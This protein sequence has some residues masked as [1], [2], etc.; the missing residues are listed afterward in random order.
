LLRFAPPALFAAAAL[1]PALL[2]SGP[3]IGQTVSGCGTATIAKADTNSIAKLTTQIACFTKAGAAASKAVADRQARVKALTP[4]PTP[5][6]APTPTP[7]A[8]SWVAC[9]KED[10]V[11]TVPGLALVRYG[12]ADKFRYLTTSTAVLCANKVFTDPITGTA[13]TCSY[14]LNASIPAGTAAAPAVVVSPTPTPTPT[15]VPTATP[16]PVAA[17]KSMTIGINVT[18][19]T[20]YNSERTFANLAQQSGGWKDPSAGW[21]STAAAKLGTTGFPIVDGQALTLNAPRQVWGGQ[22]VTISCTWS[23]SGSIRVDGLARGSISASG[24]SF[25]V[26]AGFDITKGGYPQILFYLSGLNAAKPFGDLDCREAGSQAVG[27]FEK[28]LVDELSAYK[29]L[30]FLDWSNT[31]GNPASVTLDNRSTPA[32]GGADG[33]PIETQVDLA[34]AAGTDAWFT[35][36]Y[37]ADEAYVRAM[38]ELVRD[39]L[40]KGHRAYFELSNEIWNYA[41]PVARQAS[42]EGSKQT[43]PL[44]TDYYSNNPLRA[45]QKSLWFHKILTDVFKADPS[46][47]VRVVA[48]QSDN[49]WSART[50]LA[51]P[52]LADYVDALAIAP[53]FGHSFFNAPDDKPTLADLDRLFVKLEANRVNSIAKV[54]ENKAAA[55]KYG[56]RLIAYEGGQHII[57]N[58]MAA[59]NEVYTAMQ[60]DKRMGEI[61]DRYLADWKAISPELFTVY[62][63]TGG[64]SQYGAWGIREYAGQPIGETPKRR[65]VL[66]AM[67]KE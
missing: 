61:Y 4:A 3:S 34:N 48:S 57:P 2:S 16:T 43:P 44:S 5:V 15:P 42:D 21:G 51:F 63:A 32:R 36:A 56:K 67:K 45:A 50:I 20:Y 53:Y 60:R 33:I 6:P 1:A 7:A 8:I 24:G 22:S 17:V 18:G 23:G 11:C 31:N 19:S 37:N 29:L 9:S 14:S 49:S 26:P 65:A 64:I 30:R 46:R 38:G 12:A 13:K 62:S 25:T 40:A 47:L 52:G 10:A 58:N 39:R 41:F 35:L 28:T 54:R 55:D 27:Q 66:D 59:Q